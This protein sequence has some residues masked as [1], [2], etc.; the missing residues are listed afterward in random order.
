MQLAA[1]E[2]AHRAG[3][4][5]ADGSETPARQ[6]R[7]RRPVPRRSG[8]SCRRTLGRPG[9]VASRHRRAETR[10]L[11]PGAFIRGQPRGLDAS[12]SLDRQRAEARRAPRGARR[13]TL[14]RRRD[15]ADRLPRGGAPHGATHAGRRSNPAPVMALQTACRRPGPCGPKPTQPLPGRGCRALWRHPDIVFTPPPLH[16]EA[17]C[18]VGRL[19]G[20][21]SCDPEAFEHR[22]EHRL[23]ARP[24]TP[25]R[26]ATHTGRLRP[27]V[28]CE[29]RQPRPPPGHARAE[30]RAPPGR[31]RCCRALERQQLVRRLA[32]RPHRGGDRGP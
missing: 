9:T 26:G 14:G 10:R 23:P 22:E 4:R 13:R 8:G 29:P 27:R 31:R 28:R 20:A 32:P 1:G 30:A 3:L 24:A 7:V 25:K 18:R 17:A 5:T 21:G 16:E 2:D 12:R 6:G 15:V 19:P 11:G